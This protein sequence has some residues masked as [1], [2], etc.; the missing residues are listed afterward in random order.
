MMK[1]V[2]ALLPFSWL[3]GCVV[4]LRNLMFDWKI[5]RTER[6]GVPVI[7]VGNITTGGT[8]KTPVV[9]LIVKALQERNI[10][11]AIVSRGYKRET[12]GLVEVSD[13]SSLKT[14]VRNAGD[15]AF[16]LATR[17][18]K[19]IVVVDEQRVRGARYAVERLNAQAVVLDDGFQHRA[20]HR[21]LDIV[22][23]DA[24]RSP[25]TM[26]MLPAGY[27]RDALSSLKRANAIL[28]TKVMRDTNIE[29]HKEQIGL[30][31][32]AKIF[33]SSF[34][35]VAF[36]R[37]KTG[38]SV[39]LNS[40]KG[41]QAV[42][43]CGIGQPESFKDSLDDLGIRVSSMIS[44]EDHHPYSDSD[45]RRVIEE[46]EKFKADYIITTEKDLARVSSLDFPEKYPLFYLEIEVSIH[47]EQEWNELINSAL[48]KRN[49]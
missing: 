12:H 4:V 10:R 33:S 21:D 16:Q 37:A 41:K 18:P 19:A 39:D 42:A 40:V 2:P 43:F 8:G 24:A 13:G 20:L 3:Y 7:S 6:V 29:K 5:F 28:L 34:T 9:E 26:A 38:F 22:L 32:D 45:I 30:Y 47:Q 49:N 15:E 48:G 35:I 23:I 27:R 31:S 44:F 11:C 46:Q 14:K 17:L 25:F 36:R 1:P